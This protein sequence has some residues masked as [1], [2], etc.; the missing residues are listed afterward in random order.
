M[1]VDD[2]EDEVDLTSAGVVDELAVLSLHESDDVLLA[3]E[4]N[5]SLLESFDSE[6]GSCDSVGWNSLDHDSS[7]LSS[8][9]SSVG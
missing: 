7:L 2:V 1:N 9:D 6:L 4:S 5:D 8:D 3:L